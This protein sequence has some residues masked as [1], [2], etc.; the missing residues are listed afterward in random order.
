[1][2]G[3]SGMEIL[4]GEKTGLSSTSTEFVATIFWITSG[5]GGAD[6]L[7]GGTFFFVLLLAPFSSDFLSERWWS[8]FLSEFFLSERFSDFLSD[9]LSFDQ[10]YRIFLRP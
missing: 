5:G 3:F 4:F 1:M 2:T 8:D 7:G 9:F 10:F 6:G